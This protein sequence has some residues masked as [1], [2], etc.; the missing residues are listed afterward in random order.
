[1][2]AAL[3]VPMYWLPSVPPP[4]TTVRAL[5]LARTERIE[6]DPAAGPVEFEEIH[7]VREVV[8]GPLPADALPGPAEERRLFVRVT[9]G[10]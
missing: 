2:A 4:D 10:R 7:A 1:M 3:V 6:G 8:A 5:F 9:R